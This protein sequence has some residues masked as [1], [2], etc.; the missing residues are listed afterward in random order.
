M[1]WI[2]NSFASLRVE[3]NRF[4]T[5]TRNY[6]GCYAML[7]AKPT[8]SMIAKMHGQ[9]LVLALRKNIQ[10]ERGWRSVKPLTHHRSSNRWEK[11]CLIK[12]IEIHWTIYNGYN[13]YNG[14]KEYNVHMC[15]RFF[16]RTHPLQVLCEGLQNVERACC[17]PY[18]QLVSTGRT[19]TLRRQWQQVNKSQETGQIGIG[20]PAAPALEFLSGLSA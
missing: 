3:F 19:G 5:V 14:Y 15:T 16:W 7:C 2:W 18:L 4:R 1:C 12:T 20:T 8:P 17:C 11:R 9:A 13:E 6:Q 10:R